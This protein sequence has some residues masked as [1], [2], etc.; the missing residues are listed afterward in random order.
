MIYIPDDTLESLTAKTAS[1]GD[2]FVVNMDQSNG[3]IL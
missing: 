2:V 3:I 1:I